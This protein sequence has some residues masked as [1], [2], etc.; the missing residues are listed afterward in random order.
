MRPPLNRYRVSCT[1]TYD[2]WVVA[3]T[4]EDAEEQA[5][6]EPIPDDAEV[7]QTEA[8]FEETAEPPD[9]FNPGERR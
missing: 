5:S 6:H 9:T 7:E 1:A 8:H 3:E 4:P 2:V